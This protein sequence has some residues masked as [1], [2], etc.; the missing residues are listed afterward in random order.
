MLRDPGTSIPSSGLKQS[1]KESG[2]QAQGGLEPQVR[3]LGGVTWL[4]S[5]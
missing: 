4:L 2:V 5:D 3:G 1:R